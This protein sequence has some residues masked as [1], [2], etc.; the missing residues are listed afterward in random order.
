MKQVFLPFFALLLLSL[1]VQAQRNCGATEHL[2][3]QQQQYPKYEENR[4]QIEKHT[5]KMLAQPA[6]RS[7]NGTITIPIVVHVVY[8][9]NSENISM[10]QIQ[11]QIDVLNEDFRRLNGDAAQTPNDFQ[12]VAADSEIEF[13]L[14]TVDPQ[15]NPTDGVTRTQTSNNSFGTNNTVKFS[16]SGGKNAWP[17]S[18][19]MNVWV[20][21]ISGGIL[22]YAQFPGG[23]AS[24]D[25]IVVD[26]LYF[27]TIGT[28]TPPFDLGRT[29]THEVGHYLNLR[30]IWGDGNCN[31]DDQ[32]G[33]TPRAGGPNYTG[34]SCSFPGPNSCNEGSGDLPDM[35]QNYMDYSDDGCMN[36]FTLGQKA[37]M[38]A[39]FEPGGFRTSLLNSTAC[40]PAT[41]PTC[42][43]DIQNG[44]EEGIDCGG[45]FCNACPC[46]NPAL[47][48]SITLDNYPEET[49]WAI[50]DNLGATI[51]SGGPYSNQPDGATLTE[52]IN[53]STGN[54]T[55]TI[56]D[57]YGDGICCSY[58]NGSYTL[59][60]GNGAVIA[61]GGAFSSS[62]STSFCTDPPAPTCEDGLQNGA[63]TG[64]D[65]GGPDCA[66][67]SSCS[68][69]I[70][71]GAETGV[72][73]G[74]PDC[75]PCILS[76]DDPANLAVSNVTTTSATLSWSA[77]PNAISY[78]IR[79]MPD[80]GSLITVDVPSNIHTLTGLLPAT[81]HQWQ[82]RT[83]C[84]NGNSRYIT[85]LPF[86]TQSPVCPD[87]DGDGICD[88]DDQCP[89]F[90]DNL[91][92]TACDDGDN[93]TE[94]DTYGSDCNC[95]GT[96]IDDNNN[97]ICDLDEAGCTAPVD[98]QANNLTSSS[99]LLSWS[100]VSAASGYELQYLE[101]GAPFSEL[102]S[103]NVTGNTR[104]V[105]GLSAGTS[106]LWRV[107]ALCSNEASPWSETES[108]TTTSGACPDDDNDG[109]C[110]AD[111]QCP[112]FDDN[113]IGASCNDGD[114]C[115][116]NDT[117]GADCNCTGT[118]IDTNNNM[119]CD[120]DEGCTDPVNL[121]AVAL[122][123]T[124][125]QFSWNVVAGANAYRL[126]YRPA[127]SNPVSIDIG[128]NSYTAS[129]LPTASTVQ[130]RVRALCEGENSNFIVGPTVILSDPTRNRFT[131]TG[132]ELFP[133]PTSGSFTLSLQGW[134]DRTGNIVVRSAVGRVLYQTVT[135]APE[136]T[137]DL[138]ALNIPAAVLFVTVQQ[139]G[140]APVTKRLVYKRP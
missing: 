80:G 105:S 61:S 32:V 137:I 102:L 48:L 125:A 127:G 86:T 7:V 82:V 11:S 140:L 21:D 95:A 96:L 1:S 128:N 17:A 58:G 51:A 36:L 30:H 99:A 40:G 134:G 9:T 104:L 132:F 65:C 68:D 135:T 109:V 139:E 122:S 110:N 114:E 59:T 35:F 28:A 33:D 117:Y 47:T 6:L 2:E 116:E 129:N 136:L 74:G 75:T 133:N 79:Y 88:A 69:G 18:D 112:G 119:I 43:D 103:L 71:N 94:N 52:N 22:G 90:D 37:R 121:N 77:V 108:F 8:N 57:S 29:A 131:E 98:L 45:S 115:T 4:Q 38:R 15:G 25:G 54:F 84:S 91:I 46:N 41:P 89:G 70:Q 44:D 124:A 14:A 50:T 10:A 93:C 27:G 19:Y 123:N 126:Q 23:P 34:G 85:G 16:S 78:R 97:N 87:S 118:L 107:Q 63:E 31:V 83:Q 42:D 72:D 100:P 60:D 24:T 130:W 106:Y 111:D 56:N 81:N 101:Q 64:V 92:G 66:P 20:C 73:C 120:L 12:G 13:C 26:Y 113:L 62:E 138:D 49:S 67:C 55:F 76:C 39:L 3:W 5:A 53:L